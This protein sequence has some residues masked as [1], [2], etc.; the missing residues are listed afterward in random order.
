MK[1]VKYGINKCQI[2]TTNLNILYMCK[3]AKL[4]KK[5]DKLFIYLKNKNLCSKKID[6]FLKPQRFIYGNN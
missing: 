5:I 2:K 6:I 3:E 1:F 4:L